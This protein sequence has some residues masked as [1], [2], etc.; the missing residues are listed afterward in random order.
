MNCEAKL[1]DGVL[2]YFVFSIMVQPPKQAW[3]VL[4]TFYS[5]PNASD[6][7]KGAMSFLYVDKIIKTNAR[8]SAVCL[9]IR[10]CLEARTSQV[11]ADAAIR[12]AAG[13]RDWNLMRAWRRWWIA[14]P[15]EKLTGPEGGTP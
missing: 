8:N 1:S 6:E 13:V 14:R 2:R 7:D 12:E 4:C 9:A 5:L 3:I 15:N 10:N 11:I